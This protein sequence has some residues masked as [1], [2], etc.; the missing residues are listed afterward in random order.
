MYT[1][2]VL[3]SQKNGKKYVGSTGEDIKERLTQHR[4]GSTQWTRQN[5]PFELI[6]REVVSDKV[7]ALRREKFL[8]TD[9]GR[10]FITRISETE[11]VVL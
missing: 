10:R 6:Y 3:K 1:V 5:G 7:V 4:S 9:Q 11:K 2:Y 8:K